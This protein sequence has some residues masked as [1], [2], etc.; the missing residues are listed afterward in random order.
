MVN[1]I[2]F[3]QMNQGKHGIDKFE[4]NFNRVEQNDWLNRAF[5]QHLL[6]RPKY[7]AA[8]EPE[9]KGKGNYPILPKS[10]GGLNW[11]IS[12]GKYVHFILDLLK[13]NRPLGGIGLRRMACW[14]P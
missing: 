4:T 13:M 6:W 10:K 1:H 8:V 14:H 11:A 3:E 9:A 12:T 2:E 7:H 5:M